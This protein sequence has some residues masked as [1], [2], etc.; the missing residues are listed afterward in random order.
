[1]LEAQLAYWKQQLAGSPPLLELPTDRPRPPVQT[2]RG[3]HARF[4]AA[5]SRCAE[6]LKALEPA[7]RARRCS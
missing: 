1:M 3:A 5:R 7:A 6:P 2:F 4:R